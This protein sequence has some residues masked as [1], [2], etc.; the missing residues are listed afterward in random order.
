[1]VTKTKRMASLLAV[2]MALAILPSMAYAEGETTANVGTKAEFVAAAGDK[3]ITVINVTASMDLSYPNGVG[4]S[5][6]LD[7]DG[8]TID[9]GGNTISADNFTLIFEGSNFTLQNG[10]FS[11]NGGS[12]ALFIGDNGTTDNVVIQ[13]VV[14]NGGINVFNASNVTLKDVNATGTQYYAVWCDEGGQVT[15]ESGSFQTNGTIAPSV[16]GLMSES[17]GSQLSV[18]GGNFTVKGGQSLVLESKD[19]Y[20]DPIISGGIYNVDPS[21]YVSEYSTFISYTHG[22]GTVYALGPSIEGALADA[23]EGD[24]VTVL[25]GGSVEVPHSVT[26]KNETGGEITV[27]GATVSSNEEIVAHKAVKVEAKAPTCTDG[28][29]IAHWYCKACGKYFSDEACT[30]EITEAQTQIAAKGHSAKKVDAKTATATEAGNIEYWYCAEC[31]KYFSDA[32]L[33]KEITRESTVIAATGET[34]PT[35]DPTSPPKTGDSSNPTL[36]MALLVLACA[37]TIGTVLYGRR[38]QAGKASTQA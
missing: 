18:A 37:G 34:K 3:S 30:T 15:I 36:W 12:Y 1:M 4:G 5:K 20:G 6:V 38:K 26:V 14:T 9:L 23:R 33:N 35:D 16:L 25:K 22:G 2:V 28:G 29:N 24:S 17:E 31:G 32:A 11:A 8:K 19:S 10:T 27:N 21:D 7:V 13:N